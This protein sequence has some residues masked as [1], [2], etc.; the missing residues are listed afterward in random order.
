ML[1]S[2]R[3]TVYVLCADVVA[4]SYKRQ[5]NN[6]QEESTGINMKHNEALGNVCKPKELSGSPRKPL[7]S[8]I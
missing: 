4:L 2:L 3:V 5:K 6:C 8:S 1:V 7:E